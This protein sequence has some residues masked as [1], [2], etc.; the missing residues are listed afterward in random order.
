MNADDPSAVG[1]L[2]PSSIAAVLTEYTG[3]VNETTRSHK[4][5][6][7]FHYNFPAIFSLSQHIALSSDS[8]TLFVDIEDKLG[9]ARLG[10]PVT[11]K[12]LAT[13]KKEGGVNFTMLDWMDE[14]GSQGIGKLICCRR[15]GNISS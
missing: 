14:R 7:G 12:A 3:D 2:M 15:P 6:D 1:C 10:K 5:S 4:R 13:L 9:Q 11:Q 8:A